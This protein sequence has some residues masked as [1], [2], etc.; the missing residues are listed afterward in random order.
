MVLRTAKI[1]D[2][3]FY[4]D[5]K[6][7]PSSIYWSGFSN[8]PDKNSLRNHFLRLINGE[9]LNRDFYIAEDKGVPVGYLQLTH[10]TDTEVE[11]GYGVSERFRGNGYGAF[12]IGEAKRL[13]AEMTVLVNLIGYVRDDNYSSKRCFEKN[14]FVR[15][16]RYDVR[17]FA[18][19]NADVK[20]YLYEWN[21]KMDA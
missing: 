2:F 3:N 11:I 15:R 12:L 7:E 20:M 10:N 18:I 5:L 9:I 8:A 4:Y 21:K 14:G 19:D 13:V 17:H 16:E 6:C 1:E